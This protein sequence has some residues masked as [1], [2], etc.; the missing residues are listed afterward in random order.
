MISDELV[1]DMRLW[2]HEFH[3]HPETAFEEHRTARRIAELLHSFG[4]QVTTGIGGTGVVGTLRAGKSS[5]AIGLRADMDALHLHEHSDLPYRSTRDG[6]MHACGHDGH[7]AM[8]LGAARHLAASKDFDGVVQFIFQPA[9]ENEGGGQEMIEDGL[10][11]RF[12][13]DAVFGMHNWPGLPLG[14]MAMHPGP[15]LL[16]FDLFEIRLRGKGGHAAMPNRAQ[17]VIVAQSQLVAALQTIV[18]R[19]LDPLEPAVVSVT[20]VEA[21]STWNIIPET[22]VLRGTTRYV[23]PETQQ[24]LESQMRRIVEHVSQAMDVTADLDYWYRYPATIN[25]ERETALAQ[26]VASELLGADQVRTDMRPSMASEDFA[27]MLQARP[28]CYVWLGVDGAEPGPG[29]HSAH[30]DF[31]DQAL[32][33]GAA[34]WVRLAQTALA[35]QT[36]A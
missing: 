25:S 34:Y 9:E 7:C 8:L 22:A 24:M 36:T 11:E 15:M 16:A 2:R 31:N 19:N 6:R 26:R 29:L 21:G 28:G 1:R 20:Q 18:S 13:V 35:K 12:P 27:Y 33:Y 23:N 3:S 30:F 5:R 14:Q 17:D 10:F 32:A 4:L